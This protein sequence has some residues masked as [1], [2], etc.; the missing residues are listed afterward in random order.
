MTRL[1]ILICWVAL[2]SFVAVA[3]VPKLLAALIG[4]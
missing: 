2:G 3:L 4:G 1:N